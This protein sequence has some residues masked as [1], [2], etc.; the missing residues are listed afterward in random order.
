MASGK[1]YEVIENGL[2][3]GALLY[4]DRSYIFSSVPSSLEGATYIKTSND[5]KTITDDSLI[6][7]EVNQ[8]VTVYVA[9]D[10]SVSTQLSWL[11]PQ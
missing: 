4:I 5:D 10:D 1:A 6:S 9:Y 2:Q 8:N 3:S 11:Q 7:F